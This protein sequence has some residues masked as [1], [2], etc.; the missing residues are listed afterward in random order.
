MTLLKIW[1]FS[2]AVDVVGGAAEGTAGRC[3]RG[4][5]GGGSGL[6]QALR[7]AA[8][9]HTAGN[10]Q[11]YQRGRGPYTAA[12]VTFAPLFKSAYCGINLTVK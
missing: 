5:R 9:D 6:D 3:V 2:L 7:P 4:V 1:C 8:A 12:Q 11:C 10:R